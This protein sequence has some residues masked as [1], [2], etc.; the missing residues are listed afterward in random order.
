MALLQLQNI[1]KIYAGE[2]SIAVGIRGVDL[3]FDRG[4]IVAVTGKSGSGK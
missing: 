4:E 1:G 3:S 2:G